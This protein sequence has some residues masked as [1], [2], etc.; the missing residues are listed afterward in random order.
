LKYYSF[1]KSVENYDNYFRGFVRSAK[2]KNF[3]KKF[4]K[5]DYKYRQTHVSSPSEE[6]KSL[7]DLYDK[8]NNVSTKEIEELGGYLERSLAYDAVWVLAYSLNHTLNKL[9]SIITLA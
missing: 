7:L 5:I 4:P 9:A 8:I 2:W 6:N 1:L 3:A